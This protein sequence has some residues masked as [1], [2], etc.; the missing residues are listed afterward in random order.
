MMSSCGYYEIFKNV[1]FE[2]HLRMA[3]FALNTFF[4]KY[5][6]SLN[7]KKYLNIKMSLNTKM[8]LIIEMPLNS[9]T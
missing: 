1:Y 9:T 7:I 6:K 2:E 3:V 8:L 5:K 4:C